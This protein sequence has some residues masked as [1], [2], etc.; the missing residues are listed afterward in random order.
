MQY[1]SKNNLSCFSMQ[2]SKIPLHFFIF[3][4]IMRQM[5]RIYPAFAEPKKLRQDSLRT[6]SILKAR[7]VCV[8]SSFVRQENNTKGTDCL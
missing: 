7:I 3:S 2:I 1:F 6:V 4:F 5:F 8:N